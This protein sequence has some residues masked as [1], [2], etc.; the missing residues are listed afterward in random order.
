MCTRA[1]FISLSQQH[2]TT[3]REFIAAISIRGARRGGWH[4]YRGAPGSPAGPPALHITQTITG[5]SFLETAR[6]PIFLDR[7]ALYARESIIPARPRAFVLL[8]SARVYESPGSRIISRT[9]HWR[10]L[11]FQSSA[12]QCGICLLKE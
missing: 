1:T 11:I 2:D 9:C 12:A 6:L 4:P 7:R 8:L 10:G 3:P 5:G